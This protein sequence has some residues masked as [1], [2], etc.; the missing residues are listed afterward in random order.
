MHLYD[1]FFVCLF[2]FILYSFTFNFWYDICL[3]KI[4]P[5]GILRRVIAKS[6]TIIP[7]LH[8]GWY[9]HVSF[10]RNLWALNNLCHFL[11]LNA[12]SSFCN[13]LQ[14]PFLF[15]FLEKCLLSVKFGSSL[16]TL[17]YKY[18]EYHRSLHRSFWYTESKAVPVWNTNIDSWTSGLGFGFVFFFPFCVFIF[19][20]NHV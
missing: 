18:S 4:T 8:L 11:S 17:L 16:F 10:T 13:T 3:F 5:R 15:T 7:S 19:F 2:S 14:S 9:F 1:F 6:K 12:M 20:I